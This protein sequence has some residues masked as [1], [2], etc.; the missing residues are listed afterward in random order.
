[1]VTHSRKINAGGK[2]ETEGEKEEE[3]R[4]DSQPEG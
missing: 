2:Q 1:M 3:L 4:G